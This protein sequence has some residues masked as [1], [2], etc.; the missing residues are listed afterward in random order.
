[1]ADVAGVDPFQEQLVR[2]PNGCRFGNLILNVDV[3]PGAAMLRRQLPIAGVGNS[4]LTAMHEPPW[5][6][7]HR[8]RRPAG[9]PDTSH[10]V[11]PMIRGAV[12]RRPV[13]DVRYLREANEPLWRAVGM[14]EERDRK[15]TRL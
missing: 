15:S 13:G 12:R 7:E 9:K 1:M 8:E 11:I 14:T 6:I 2:Q 5:R 4:A 10:A 3:D